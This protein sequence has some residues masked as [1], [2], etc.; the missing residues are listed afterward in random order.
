MVQHASDLRFH[1]AVEV[2]Y[3]LCAYVDSVSCS[4]GDAIHALD[5]AGDDLYVLAISL[6]GLVEGG[7][8]E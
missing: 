6:V 3:V 2:L 5:E 7:P 4:V 1:V 8:D